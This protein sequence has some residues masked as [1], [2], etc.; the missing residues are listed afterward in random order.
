[1]LKFI[2]GG[3]LLR[4]ICSNSNHDSDQPSV[5][6]HVQSFLENLRR[7]IFS[8]VCR[9]C[10]WLHCFCYI[11][12]GPYTSSHCCLGDR[13]TEFSTVYDASQFIFSKG[14]NSTA[15]IISPALWSICI[16]QQLYICGYLQTDSQTKRQRSEKWNWVCTCSNRRYK[17]QKL[18]NVNS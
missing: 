5:P 15:S 4:G 3:Q 8:T 7:S 16:D 9:F 2:S 10:V 14:V 1:M 13:N 17:S 12:Y 18:L 6:I 11:P